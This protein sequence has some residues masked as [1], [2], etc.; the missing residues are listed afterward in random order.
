MLV[1]LTPAL[2][3]YLQQRSQIEQLKDQKSQAS[4]EVARLQ[5]QKQQWLDPKYVKQQAAE[6]LGYAP[7]GQQITIYVDRSGKKHATTKTSGVENF[8][9]MSKLPWYGQVW[10]S[11][12]KSTKQDN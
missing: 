6:R 7:A 1:I 11:V 9:S 3:S 8:S 2:R 10:G 4:S 5:H 12:A